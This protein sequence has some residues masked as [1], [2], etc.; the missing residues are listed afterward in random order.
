[1]GILVVAGVGAYF[2]ALA[3]VG[4]RVRQFRQK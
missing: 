3:L 1:M 2:L 4:V